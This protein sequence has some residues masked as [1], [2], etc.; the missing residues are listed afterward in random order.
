MSPTATYPIDLERKANEPIAEGIHP[1]TVQSFE[2]GKK[3]E[4]GSHPYIILTCA[5]NSPA[6][7]GKTARLFLS[8]SPNARWRLE[9]FLN[10]INAPEEGMATA[11]KF[12][13]RKFRAQ[14]KHEEY[15]GRPQAKLEALFRLTDRPAGSPTSSPKPVVKSATK[16]PRTK[17]GTEGVPEASQDEIPF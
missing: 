6:E 3:E 1:F 15:Q 11:D 14:V 5:C 10:A 17:Q 4:E 16:S 8:L 9:D 2:E 7:E 13:K 12:L